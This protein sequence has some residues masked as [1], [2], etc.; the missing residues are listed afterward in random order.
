MQ[1]DS[2]CCHSRD[3]ASTAAHF[4]T[5]I[6]A[7]SHLHLTDHPSTR[8]SGSFNPSSILLAFIMAI[9]SVWVASSE[10]HSERRIDTSLTVQQLKV[11]L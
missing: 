10:T 8:F 9:I 7:I 2:G 6:T 4:L 5:V 1:L 3:L 11:S